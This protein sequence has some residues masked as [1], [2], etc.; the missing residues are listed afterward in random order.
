M[1]LPVINQTTKFRIC[2]TAAYIHFTHY[3]SDTILHLGAQEQ[4]R[5]CRHGASH[6]SV[7][8]LTVDE[9]VK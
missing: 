2:Y 9:E 8:G 4:D 6:S 7:G 3:V 5:L 1:M